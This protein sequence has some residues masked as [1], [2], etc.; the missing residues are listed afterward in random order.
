[1]YATS[2]AAVR[3]ELADEIRVQTE[4][5][6]GEGIEFEVWDA[7]LMPPW[8]KGKPSLV[9]DFFGRTW[10][11]S[12]C[13]REAVDRLGTRLDAGQ[14]GDLRDQLQRFYTAMFDVT[15]SGMIG[16]RQAGAPRLAVRDRFVLP[17]VLV[18][19]RPARGKNHGSRR[20][21]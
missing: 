15:D 19:G 3:S 5:L 21:S 14:V 11:E 7:D 6:R 4:R 12:F 18:T 17:D 20:C 16:L 10:A 13:G 9:Y 8:L 1:V 2:L